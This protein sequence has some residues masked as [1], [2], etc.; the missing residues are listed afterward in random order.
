MTA[1]EPRSPSS[2]LSWAQFDGAKYRV[3]VSAGDS[4]ITLSPWSKGSPGPASPFPVT[5]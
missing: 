5:T 3:S 2:A 1:V 4:S